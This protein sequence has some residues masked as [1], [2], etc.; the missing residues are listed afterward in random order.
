MLFAIAAF[1]ASST[2]YPLEIQSHLNINGPQPD[3]LICHDS[4]VGGIGTA[5]RKF[6]VTLRT[7][8]GLLCCDPTGA[9]DN[10]LDQDKANKDDSDGGGVDDITELIAGGNPSD[11]SDD[12][13]GGAEGEGEA[14][15]PPGGGDIPKQVEYGFGCGASSVAG[16]APVIVALV[17]VRRRRR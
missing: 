2:T 5:N 17:V 8:Y 15:P 14:R 10:A 9:L 7:K 12:N 16:I 11:A 13:V 1:V 3:C 4:E 6:A